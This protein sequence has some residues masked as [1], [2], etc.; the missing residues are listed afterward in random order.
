[1]ATVAVVCSR[2]ATLPSQA[3]EQNLLTFMAPQLHKPLLTQQGAST[4]GGTRVQ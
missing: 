2:A 1:M 3:P 4:D